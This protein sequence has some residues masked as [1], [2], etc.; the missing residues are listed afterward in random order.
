MRS[1]RSLICDA[2][3]SF[4]GT[5]YVGNFRENLPPGAI[6]VGWLTKAIL[7][8]GG[9]TGR[10]GGVGD[11]GE[12]RGEERGGEEV[13]K[14]CF[15]VRGNVELEPPTEDLCGEDFDVPIPN[16]DL[17]PE[18][19]TEPEVGAEICSGGVPRLC[20]TDRLRAA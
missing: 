15:S 16:P 5:G 2:K 12:E 10:G 8:G 11:E 9:T 3:L 1:W 14:D 6:K 13:E 7:E 17:R 18:R 20:S 4:S 19:S